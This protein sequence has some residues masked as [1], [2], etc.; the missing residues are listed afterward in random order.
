M[1]RFLIANTAW[2]ATFA[3]MRTF[4]VLY[5]IQ[6][7]DQPLYVSSAVLAVV[8]GGYVAAAAFSGPFG[9]RFGLARVIL[10]ASLVYGLGLTLVGASRSSGTGGTTPARLPGRRR[11]RA[12]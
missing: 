5:I 12:P 10:A 11:R 6:G 8:A 9:D 2:E 4:V 3:G 1:R 7:L